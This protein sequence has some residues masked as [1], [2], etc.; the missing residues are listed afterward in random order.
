MQLNVRM[1]HYV[2]KAASTREVWVLKL[3]TGRRAVLGKLSVIFILGWQMLN[4]WER[5]ILLVTWKEI[6]EGSLMLLNHRISS[7]V[8]GVRV[9]AVTMIYWN[10]GLRVIITKLSV[11]NLKLAVSCWLLLNIQWIC[12]LNLF[13]RWWGEIIG[14]KSLLSSHIHHIYNHYWLEVISSLEY[15]LSQLLSLFR[16]DCCLMV[17]VQSNLSRWWRIQH[18]SFHYSTL[19]HLEL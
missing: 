2:L 18:H 8:I 10:E 11:I 1:R 4:L 5:V 17:L 13:L 19:F 6:L 9:I 12:L 7:L 15:T 16:W 14:C 3:L